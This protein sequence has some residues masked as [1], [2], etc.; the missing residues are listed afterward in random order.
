MSQNTSQASA[1]DWAK[2]GELIR[3]IP[4]ALITTVD[5]DGRF[6]SR[7][8]QTLKFEA[9]RTLWFFTD[10]SSPKVDELRR[11]ERLS[12][13]YADP[14]KNVYVAVN[15]CGHLLRDPSRAKELWTVEQ[16]ASYLLAAAA[17]AATGTPAG[18]IGE[19]RKING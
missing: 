5:R 16:R 7:P 12:L 6:H 17:A 1:G 8:V 3:E 2:L 4:V 9:D 15:G 19:N 11:D 18:V 14:A 13:A 10:W